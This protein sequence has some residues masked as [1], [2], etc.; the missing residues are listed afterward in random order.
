MDPF[1]KTAVV[2]TA[3]AGTQLPASGSAIVPLTQQLPTETGERSFLLAA[4]AQAIY[5]Q[6]G[7]VA[8]E[9]PETLPVAEPD[10]KPACSL[11]IAQLIEALF[12]P[13]HDILLTEAL[14]RL[15]R[16]QQRLPHE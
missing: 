6:A 2:G 8:S 4:A 1:L 7:L 3:Q 9:A 11:R 12:Q 13:A 14:Q 5:T 16:T 10:T 15:Q